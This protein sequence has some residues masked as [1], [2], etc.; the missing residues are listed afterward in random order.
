MFQ[1]PPNPIPNADTSFLMGESIVEEWLR[2]LGLVH[3]TQAFLDNGYDDLEVCKQIGDLDLDAI[4]VLK[5]EHRQEILNAVKV[6]REQG[7]TAVYFTL[8]NPDYQDCNGLY[9]DYAGTGLGHVADQLPGKLAAFGRACGGAA[10][11]PAVPPYPWG[12]GAT[13]HGFLT[14]PKLQLT[15]IVRDRLAAADINLAAAPY[16]TQVRN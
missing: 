1:A 14:Y 15:S 11:L 4:G 7:G 8:E 2:S 16:V 10:S 13:D 6:L 9:T 12:Q 3:Y 5:S